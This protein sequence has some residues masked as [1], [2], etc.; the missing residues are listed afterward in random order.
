MYERRGG[1]AEAGGEVP[2]PE[3]EDAETWALQS[4]AGCFSAFKRLRATKWVVEAL[5]RQLERL[6][7]KARAHQ[8]V[9]LLLET[10]EESI[11]KEAVLGIWGN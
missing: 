9:R 10:R 8:L 2:G 1:P 6:P 3:G 11:P 7:R 5:V 4:V